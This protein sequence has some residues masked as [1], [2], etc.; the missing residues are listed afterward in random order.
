MRQIK[1]EL[2]SAG[3][4]TWQKILNRLQVWNLFTNSEQILRAADCEMLAEE[5]EGLFRQT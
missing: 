5:A 3:A 1:L 2:F 4:C